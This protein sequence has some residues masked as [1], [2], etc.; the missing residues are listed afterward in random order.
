[1]KLL[2]FSILLVT[3]QIQAH[4]GV[5]LGKCMQKAF[6]ETIDSYRVIQDRIKVEKLRPKRLNELGYEVI[7]IPTG[8]TGYL[9]RRLSDSNDKVIMS[10]FSE[11]VQEKYYSFDKDDLARIKISE[12]SESL[13]EFISC[14]SSSDH[15]E[16]LQGILKRRNLKLIEDTLLLMTK[17]PLKDFSKKTLGELNMSYCN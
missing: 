15:G 3:T 11:L 13:E 10:L 16:A 6:Q 5:K 1:M 7:E 17:T 4:D 2:F 12:I 8:E 9:C 14:Y